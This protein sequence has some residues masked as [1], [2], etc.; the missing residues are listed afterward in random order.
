MSYAVVRTGGKQLRVS[1][2]EAVRVEKLAGAVGDNVEFSEV[3]LLAS[4]DLHATTLPVAVAPVART[5][6]P[7]LV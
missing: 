1:P 4:E 6:L 3:L 2:G 5:A 7:L